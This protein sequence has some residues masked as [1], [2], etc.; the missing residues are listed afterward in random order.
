MAATLK[1]T[2]S[3]L[4]I[5]PGAMGM[6]RWRSEALCTITKRP[7]EAK[8]TRSKV[9]NQSSRGQMAIVCSSSFFLFFF[10]REPS[11]VASELFETKPT[12]KLH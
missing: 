7:S 6:T 3:L 4:N 1:L 8:E 5:R 2:M 12:Q 10:F 11:A 9:V